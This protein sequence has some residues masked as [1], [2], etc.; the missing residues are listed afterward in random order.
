[1]KRQLLAACAAASLAG[2]SV[3]PIPPVSLQDYS[4]PVVAG[5]ANRVCYTLVSTDPNRW[6]AASA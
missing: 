3:V 2:C 6:S 4:V 5:V 1:M